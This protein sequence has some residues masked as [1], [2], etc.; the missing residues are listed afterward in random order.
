MAYVKNA[1][2]PFKRRPEQFNAAVDVLQQAIVFFVFF[3]A[4]FAF[5]SLTLYSTIILLPL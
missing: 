3:I 4:F 2:E 5:Y 1:P